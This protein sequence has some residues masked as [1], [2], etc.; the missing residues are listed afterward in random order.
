MCDSGRTIFPDFQLGGGRITDSRTFMGRSL[1]EIVLESTDIVAIIGERVSLKRAGKNYIGLCP[2]HDDHKPSFSVSSEKQIFR[3]WSCGVGGDVIKFVQLSEKVDFPEALRL[4][5]QRAGINLAR[6]AG[7]RRAAQAREQL[8]DALR[9]AVR[10][11]QRNLESPAG[12]VARAY[13]DRRGLAPES[14]TRH[15][16]GFAVDGWQDVVNAARRAGIANE[17]LQQAGLITS[18]DSGRLYDRFR[19]RLIFPIRDH[20]GRPV[21]LGGR[22]LG[23]DPAKYLNSPETALFSKSHILYALDLA[24]PA[25]EAGG[26]AI[27]VEGYMDAVMLHQFGFTNVVA[28]LGTAL[29]DAHVKLLRRFARSIILCFDGDEAG[30]KAA[31]RGVETALRTGADVRVMLLPGGQDPADCVVTGGREAFA[32]QLP[33]AVDALRFKWERTAALI[34][35]ADARS[36]RVAVESFLGFVTRS[37]MAGGIDPLQQG[38]LVG[39]LSDLLS[40]PAAS[41]YEMLARSKQARRI[42]PSSAENDGTIPEYLRSIRGLP[43]G[44]VSAAEETLG[45]LVTSSDNLRLIDDS[46]P[47]ALARCEMWFRLYDLCLNLVEE[48]GVYDRAAVLERCEDSTLFD[49]IRA[50]CARV[51]G[52]ADGDAVFRSAIKRLASEV[53]LLEVEELRCQLRDALPNSDAAQKF[54][55]QVLLARRW[56]GGP[57]GEG[58][59]LG[60]ERSVRTGG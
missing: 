58:R 52:A 18:G 15:S 57:E 47:A 10:H 27:V 8:Q 39:R 26:E 53:D 22:T 9:W 51:D 60:A 13:A 50:A 31:D 2:F 56:H 35:L 59:F 30:I 48:S 28:T 20:L 33:K 12:A 3:C 29:T 14:L 6:E 42:S 40:V 36:R 55:Q 7:Q 38:L 54:Q 5:A 21:A 43:A 41:V 19:N 32:A 16:L 46:V 1:K 44:L 25:I 23:D 49:L 4:L 24:R 45:F 17:T 34:G 37:A 11:F